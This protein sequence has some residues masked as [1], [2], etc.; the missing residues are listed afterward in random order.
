MFLLVRIKFFS[1]RGLDFCINF[2]SIFM[3][4]RP[5]FTPFGLPWPPPLTR[6]A[7][8]PYFTSFMMPSRIDNFMILTSFWLHFNVIWEAFFSDFSRKSKMCDLMFYLGESIENQDFL[9]SWG[10][11]LAPISYVF[12]GSLPRLDFYW[13]LNDFGSPFGPL[14]ATFLHKIG[15]ENTLENNMKNWIKNVASRVPQPPV[16]LVQQGTGKHTGL[17]H[18]LYKK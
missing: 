4:F 15:N 6:P 2:S 9:R 14:L 7:F 12:P 5:I 17:C 3:I 13:F 18:S 8:W 11:V 16:N 1:L 10:E